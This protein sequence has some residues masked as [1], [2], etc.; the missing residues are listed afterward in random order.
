MRHD[1]AEGK[2]TV[3]SSN[4]NLVALRNGEPWKRE[5]LGDQ[6]VYA[7]LAEVDQ[8]KQERDEYQQAADKL[9]MQNKVLRDALGGLLALTE[10]QSIYNCMEP[11]RCVARA[12]LKGE[13]K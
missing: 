7:M 6:L 8:L 2:Y 3:I 5:L 9:A 1:F 11:Q 13:V 4:G 12:A 10:G